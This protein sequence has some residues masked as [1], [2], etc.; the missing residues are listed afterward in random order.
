MTR[1][2]P[3]VDRDLKAAET[4]I[5]TIKNS[6]GTL[7][8]WVVN[9]DVSNKQTVSDLQVVNST[10]ESLKEKI[11]SVR[12][13]LVGV[14]LT[15]QFLK[16][17]PSI[18]KVDEKGLSVLGAA[19]PW[20]KFITDRVKDLE[21][22]MRSEKEKVIAKAKAAAEKY[23]LGAEERFDKIS[24]TVTTHGNSIEKLQTALKNS[25]ESLKRAQDDPKNRLAAG[26]DKQRKNA[27]RG[28]DTASPTVR[29]VAGD[30]KL[31]RGAVDE[32]I[33]S[34]GSV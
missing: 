31:L 30:V 7:T 23:S 6:L 10:L 2:L 19:R 3:E 33:K 34:L 8:T 21:N 20:P 12:Y 17:D 32:L 15:G 16:V 5:S 24:E 13:M 14:V 29:G 4:G 22:K 25:A 9:L 28:I 27:V 26:T 1:S 11:K 18:I